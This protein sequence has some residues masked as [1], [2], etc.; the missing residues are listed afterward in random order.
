[1]L[2]AAAYAVSEA[3]RQMFTCKSTIFKEG[4]P[5]KPKVVLVGLL[6]HMVGEHCM[7]V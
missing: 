1:M 2:Q 7:N 5:G 3:H 6:G 4:L